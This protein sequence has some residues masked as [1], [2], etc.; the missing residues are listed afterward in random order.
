MKKCPICNHKLYGEKGK[1]R[2]CKYCGYV[3]KLSEV[4]GI[5][6]IEQLSNKQ[7]P[8]TNL[9]KII[10]ITRKSI[11]EFE[12]FNY[13]VEKYANPY[14]IMQQHKELIKMTKRFTTRM[15]QI[16]ELAEVKE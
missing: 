2:S 7:E 3:N 5:P 4:I 14:V 6:K 16:R 11:D 13:N 8:K 10:E 15:N 9:I 1:E 12:T